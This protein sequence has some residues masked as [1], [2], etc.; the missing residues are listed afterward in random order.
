MF[1]L[2]GIQLDWSFPN[3]ES[4]FYAIKFHHKL[5]GYKDPCNDDI[6]KLMFEAAKRL[7]QHKVCKKKPI[8]VEH[9]DILFKKLMVNST[10]TLSNVRTMVIC[11]LGFCGF[12]RYSEISNLKR[13]D[14]Y[15]YTTHMKLFIEKSKTDIYRE[16]SWLYISKCD[17][18]LC[19]VK[20]LLLYLEMT[21]LTNNDSEEFLFRGIT[22]TKKD[23]IGKLRK[24]VKGLSYTRM[25]EILLN[26]LASIG[27]D[28]SKFG[29]HSLRAGGA[30]AAANNGVKD[31]LFKRH[32]RWKS[33][34]AKD[35][36][37]EDDV[38]ALLSVT[39]SL[40]IP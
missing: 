4:A 20:N 1:I 32:G 17:S 7:S 30:T 21:K 6:V 14:V 38:K 33:E 23:K 5:L 26:E 8:T 27:L 31:R 18:E 2:N 39:K 9:L 29:L 11:L 16:G 28:K 24:A 35:G 12:M 19:P 15:F 25:R 22:V 37:V 10:R 36:Y 3:I 34:K 13:C 40:G